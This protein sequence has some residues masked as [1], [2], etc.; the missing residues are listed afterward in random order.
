MGYNAPMRRT[1][2]VALVLLLGGAAASLA[3][4]CGGDD[5]VIVADGGTDGTTDGTLDDGN[6]FLDGSSTLDGA[7]GNDGSWNGS[8]GGCKPLAQQCTTAGECCTGTCSNGSCQPSS[9]VS[10]NL[11]CGVNTD[12]CS[13]TCTA[14]KCAP[15]N[16]KCKTLGNACTSGNDCCS[17][18]C[19]G[20]ICGQPSYCG[21]NGD[22]CTKA[23][24][25]C[26]SVCTITGNSKFGLCDQPKSGGCSLDGV[27]CG[28]SGA[29]GG[30]VYV[31]G[32]IP[33][34]GGAC[35]SRACAPYGNTGV[36][37][38]QQA[39]GCHPVGDLCASAANCCGGSG[40]NPT[41]KCNKANVNDPVGVCSNPNGC[42]PNGDICRLQTNQCN[43]TDNCC[44]GN[45]QQFDTCR[46]DSIGVPRCSYKGGDAG[47]CVP[48]GQACSS[49]ADCCNL[50]PCVPNING[51]NPPFVCYQNACVPASGPCT[52]SADCCPG[53]NCFIQQGQT[54]GSCKPFVPPPPPSDGGTVDGGTDAGTCSTYGQICTTSGDCCNGVPCTGG[55]CVI[56]VN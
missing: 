8:D 44:S 38:C 1:P 12:C 42:K 50:S 17:T 27:L 40:L 22:I 36:L 43:A 30:V 56:I 48:S 52:T 18:Y 47:A 7:G 28:G 49:S 4:A 19:T 23:S 53:N 13:G 31:D 24:D 5:S 3:F 33:Q 25:C 46:Q 35:C 39:S 37:I 34:C 6:G 9:C 14:G 45:V 41:V 20:G 32:G 55:R 26:G 2:K 11:A 51:P 15:L 16:N 10:D 54:S 21:Q 29:D